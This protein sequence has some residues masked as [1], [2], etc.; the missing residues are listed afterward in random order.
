MGK[1]TVKITSLILCVILLAVAAFMFAN[2]F[3]KKNVYSGSK[4]DPKNAYVSG[5][6]DNFIINAN[7]FVGFSVMGAAAFVGAALFGALFLHLVSKTKKEKKTPQPVEAY[8]GAP[9][10][11]TPPPQFTNPAPQ[12]GTTPPYGTPQ[13]GGQQPYTPEPGQYGG[14]SNDDFFKS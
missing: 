8:Y 12:Y 14:T 9:Q 4:S 7:Y 5:D 10:Q 6:A 2:A 13:Q 3:N 11:Q 1:T